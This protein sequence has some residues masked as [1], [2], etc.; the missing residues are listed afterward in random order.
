LL[1]YRGLD[2]I[3]RNTRVEFATAPTSLTASSGR[4]RIALEP[5][6]ASEVQVSFSCD[7][8]QRTPAILPYDE[9]FSVNERALGRY[10]SSTC[11]V[12][13]SNEQFD[14][15]TNRSVADLFMLV[16][17]TRDGPYPYA[18][19]PWFST[20]FGR[21]GIITAFECL[22]AQPALARGVLAH[23]AATQATGSDAARDAEPGKILHERR[24]GEM[25]GLGEIPFG[26]YY[27]TVDATPLFVMLAD[28]YYERTAD[29]EFLD[30]IWPNI[31][32]AL[33]WIDTHGDLDGDGFVE[34]ERRRESGLIN[35]G[36]KD[37]EDS[38]FHADGTLAEA[39]IALAEVQ[40]YVYA[41]KTG[42]ARLL[43][44]RGDIERADA[45][46]A[47]AERL[48]DRFDE[49]FFCEELGTYALA[50]DGDKRTCRVRSSNAGHCLWTG[51]A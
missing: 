28:A 1:G 44:I 51:I 21:D 19:V 6:A 30:S 26:R 15:W 32:G 48:K 8:G 42:A 24:D 5:A 27:G 49:S 25:A 43:R 37:S 41:A 13:S 10:K 36:W 12:L 14:D 17:D 45:L 39:P 31:E 23:L 33:L 4:Y 46:S 18:G 3:V 2:D 9:A 16:S 47:D 38:V 34:Y 35:Q 20:V 40:G 11:R 50:L 7:V 22:W 29:R